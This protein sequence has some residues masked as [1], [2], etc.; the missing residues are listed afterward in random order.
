MVDDCA[1]CHIIYF[2]K[3]NKSPRIFFIQSRLLVDKF[4]YFSRG[5][6]DGKEMIA[7]TER[8]V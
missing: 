3:R 2:D 4:S 8:F 7:C 1:V 6:A 5:S